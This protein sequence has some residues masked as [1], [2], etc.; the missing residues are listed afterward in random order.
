MNGDAMEKAERL[1]A[2]AKAVDRAAGDPLDLRVSAP[3]D[4]EFDD[5][6]LDDEAEASR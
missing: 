3:D 4:E 6:E 5:K 1:L 2:A